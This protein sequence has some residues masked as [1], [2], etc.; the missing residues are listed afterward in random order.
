MKLESTGK[1]MQ[2]VACRI[3]ARQMEEIC[4]GRLSDFEIQTPRNPYLVIVYEAAA[5]EL[6]KRY[7]ALQRYLDCE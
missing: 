6:A 5:D 2:V 3:T 1:C 4:L 7:R